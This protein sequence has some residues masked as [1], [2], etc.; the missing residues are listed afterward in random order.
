MSSGNPIGGSYRSL[1]S[2][3]HHHVYNDCSS[4]NTVG[5]VPL[6]ALDNVRVH[7]SLTPPS[8]NL[9]V[10]AV[11]S[12]RVIEMNLRKCLYN[13]IYNSS[14]TQHQAQCTYKILMRPNKKTPRILS[15]SQQI[16]FFILSYNNL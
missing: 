2:L 14:I 6:P 5:V 3:L 4:E 12:F 13:S 8:L 15:L 7:G 9:G 10:T 1:Y 11:T 16:R